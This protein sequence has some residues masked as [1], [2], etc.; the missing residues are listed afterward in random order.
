MNTIL[1]KLLSLPCTH[2]SMSFAGFPSLSESKEMVRMI[3][4]KLVP[5]LLKFKSLSDPVADGTT[6]MRC[7][8]I[9]LDRGFSSRWCVSNGKRASA[10]MSTPLLFMT[11]YNI[12][13]QRGVERFYAEKQRSRC[14]GC[15]CARYATRRRI[16]RTFSRNVS[17]RRS[18]LDSRYFSITPPERIA[19]LAKYAGGFWYVVSRTGSH[20]RTRWFFWSSG[21]KN[22][23]NTKCFRSSYRTCVWSEYTGTRRNHTREGRYGS[24]GKCCTEHISSDDRPFLK[25]LSK[26]RNFFAL[27]QKAPSAWKTSIYSILFSVNFYPNVWGDITEEFRFKKSVFFANNLFWELP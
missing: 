14:T 4:T 27:S 7:N 16:H 19:L 24:G 2:D 23:G 26:Q 20:R 5:M 1:K 8:E 18:L 13:F 3:W 10:E 15:Y 25:N 12:V 22:S 9:S 6:M 11:Y 17:K 21:W